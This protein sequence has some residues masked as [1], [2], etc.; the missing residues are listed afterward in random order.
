M[1]HDLLNK[2]GEFISNVHAL[3]QELGN[4]D[5]DVFI[6]LVVIYLSSMYG[7]NIW[8]LCSDSAN[9]MYTSWNVLVRNAFNLPFATHRYI[10]QDITSTQ[11]IRVSLRR[12]FVKFYFQLNQCTKREVRQLVNIQKNDF[13]STFGRNCRNICIENNINSIEQVNVKNICMPIKTPVS[14]SWRLPLLK[15]LLCIREGLI[16]V[17]LSEAEINQ[18]INFVCTS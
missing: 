2:R 17:D 16:T 1:C 13:R 18:L 3:R 10:L 11:H 14:E 8:D 4:Q 12:R 6:K 7:S 9:K 15:E 5:P